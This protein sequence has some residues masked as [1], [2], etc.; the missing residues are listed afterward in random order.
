MKGSKNTYRI[1]PYEYIHVL[2]KN[3]N[4]SKLIVGPVTYIREE[5]EEVQT[6]EHAQKMLVLPPCG[7]C[8]ISDPIMLQDNQPIYD[9]N[10]QVKLQLGENE[11]RFQED[12]EMPFPLYP[13]ESLVTGPVVM[14]RAYQL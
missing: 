8:V 6:G 3:N 13:G 10:N 1:K 5:N 2:N 7:Y 4:V 9:N 11:I 12:Y 14:T